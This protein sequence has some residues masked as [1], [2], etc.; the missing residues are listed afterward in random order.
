[1]SRS[2]KKGPYIDEKL[3][4]KIRELNQKRKK[5]IIKT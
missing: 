2:V 1:M 4:N 5:N 3:L